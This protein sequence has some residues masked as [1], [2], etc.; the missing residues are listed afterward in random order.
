MAFN[1]SAGKCSQTLKSCSNNEHG[2][3]EVIVLTFD[4]IH[5]LT[6]GF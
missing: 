2:L 1:I 6:V 3:E 5:K 4:N